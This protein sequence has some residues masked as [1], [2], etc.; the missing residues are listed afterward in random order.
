LR[1]RDAVEVFRI[2]EIGMTMVA[3]FVAGDER[4]EERPVFHRSLFRTWLIS[5]PRKAMS[6]PARIGAWMSQLA[7]VRVNRGST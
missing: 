5:P 6:L 1:P 4:L 3:A 7:L 2:A